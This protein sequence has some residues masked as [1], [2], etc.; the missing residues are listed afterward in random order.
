MPYI[1]NVDAGDLLGRTGFIFAVTS[2]LLFAATWFLVPDTSNLSIEE[3]DEAYAQRIPARR[4][5]SGCL[6]GFHEMT[7]R[8]GK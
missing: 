6:E 7:D 8:N 1:Y 3:L 5:R 2:V 4:I